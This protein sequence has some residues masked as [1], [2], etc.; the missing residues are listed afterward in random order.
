[1][2]RIDFQEAKALLRKNDR[3][4]IVTHAN[5]DGDTL[6]CAFAL[7]RALKKIGK[8]AKVVNEKSI[9]EKYS[10]IFFESDEFE[11][12]EAVIAV[13]I[14][15]EKLMGKL[16]SKYAGRTLLCIDHHPSNTGYAENLLLCGDAAAACEIIFLLIKE[17][18]TEIDE[19]M[20]TALYTG[21]STDT[22][23]FRYSNVT[24]DTHRYAAELID[25]GADHV[26]S[27]TLM[28]ETKSKSE[29]ILQRMALEKMQ[30]LFDGKAAI[31]SLTK[32]MFLES[33]ADESDADAIKS[34]PRQ[35]EG[36]KIGVTLREGDG[37]FHV[38]LRTNAP[39]DASEICKKFG[40]GGHARAAGCE[41]ALGEEE[42]KA[43]IIKAIRCYLE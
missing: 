31:I 18:D 15:D 14:A 29:F 34:I 3:F 42:T 32:K 39:Y 6:G 20:A 40:G 16:Q 7:L 8:T 35:I 27:D 43:E 2:N 37:V 30:V 36:V 10:F 41:I 33:G 1:M 26:K 25:L 9:P 12:D 13:D 22:G 38:S 21:I 28:F 24:S 23:C 5:P 17:M 11:D 19:N 4:A